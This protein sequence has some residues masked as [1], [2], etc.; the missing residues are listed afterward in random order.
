MKKLAN[1]IKKSIGF[2]SKYGPKFIGNLRSVC[3][4]S[5]DPINSSDK[6]ISNF[7]CT[8]W[9]NGEGFDISIDKYNTYSNKSEVLNLNLST[10]DINGIIACLIELNYFE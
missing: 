7:N 6:L 9:D 8:K 2:N 1:K 5:N 4:E 10:S 3:F